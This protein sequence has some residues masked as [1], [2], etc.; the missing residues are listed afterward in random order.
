MG[1]DSAM[2]TFLQYYRNCFSTIDNA[3]N[4]HRIDYYTT[5][6]AAG[7]HIKRSEEKIHDGCGIGSLICDASTFPTASEAMTM[8]WNR[9]DRLNAWAHEHWCCHNAATYSLGN[10]KLVLRSTSNAYSS[11]VYA[12]HN[13]Q[14]NLMRH[15]KADKVRCAS[16]TP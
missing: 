5:M 1:V 4:F 2:S 15:S 7:A 3:V 12:N 9:N 10:I 8:D 16:S 13:L 11:V 14:I 6:L